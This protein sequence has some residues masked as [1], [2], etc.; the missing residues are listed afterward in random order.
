MEIDFPNQ[1]TQDNLNLVYFNLKDFEFIYHYRYQ[2]ADGPLVIDKSNYSIHFLKRFYP[3]DENQLGL[4]YAK[5]NK[6]WIYQ[7]NNNHLIFDLRQ[8]VKLFKQVGQIILDIDKNNTL[9][10]SIL[11]KILFLLLALVIT[12]ASIFFIIRKKKSTLNQKDKNTNLE[13]KIITKENNLIIK[14]LIRL[15]GKTI[16]GEMLDDILGIQT[17]PNLDTKRVMRSKHLKSINEI[18][19][20]KTGKDLIQRLKSE[21]DKRIILYSIVQQ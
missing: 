10:I 9:S 2:A 14:E 15:N 4:V 16:S 19:Q 1:K 7:V 13:F 12:G 8:E 20:R 6:L 3:H 17:I 5:E 18:N 21:D 11:H